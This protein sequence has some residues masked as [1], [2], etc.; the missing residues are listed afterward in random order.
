[1]PEGLFKGLD[2]RQ[3]AGRIRGAPVELPRDE[4]VKESKDAEHRLY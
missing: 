1:M 2:L 4:A 3:D